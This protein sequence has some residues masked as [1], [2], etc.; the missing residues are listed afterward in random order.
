MIFSN[1]FRFIDDLC[2]IVNHLEFGRNF[3]NIYPSELLLKKENIST[4]EASFLDL[5]IIIENVKF[6]AQL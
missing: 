4:S 1:T 2:A 5:S 3:K 6:K